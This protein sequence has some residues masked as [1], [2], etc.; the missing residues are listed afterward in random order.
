MIYSNIE[1]HSAA[2]PSDE[3]IAGTFVVALYEGLHY[4]GEVIQDDLEYVT[5][6]FMQCT[7]DKLHRFKWPTRKD[8]LD[9]L[10]E[11]IVCKIKAPIQHSK[12]VFNAEIPSGLNLGL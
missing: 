6:N 5:V 2:F 3:F 1:A 12:R 7:S 10:K 9:I 4:I 11:V 8:Q